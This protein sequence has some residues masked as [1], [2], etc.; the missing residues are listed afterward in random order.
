MKHLTNA[1]LS[2][3]SLLAA[4]G[5]LLATPLLSSRTWRALAQQAGGGPIRWSLTGVTDLVSLDPAKA[6]DLPGFTVIGVLYGGLVKLDESLQVAPS[7][8]EEW[9]V[10]TD[11]LTYTFTLRNGIT[12]S[13]GTPITADDVVWTFNH[14]LDPTTG[15][16]TG[17]Y[18]FT[19][20]AGADDVAAGKATE[21]SGV[22][23][24]DDKTVAITIKEPAAYFLSSLVAGPSKILSKTAMAD[25]N[26]EGKITS[27]PFM[28]QTWNHGQSLDLVPNPTFYEPVTGVTQLS[29]VFNQDSETGYQLY[30]TG[31]VDILGSSQAP[32]PAARVPEV[33]DS[34]DFKSTPAFN[35]RYVGFNNVQKPFDDVRVRQALTHAIDRDTLANAVLGGTVTPT[36]R[37]LPA[38]FPASDKPVKG[39][40]FDPAAA[41][42]LLTQAGID[43]KSLSFTLTYGVEGD[44]EKVVTVLQSMW[45]E[46]LGISVK[47]EPLELATFSSRLNDTYVD[48][49]KGIQSYYSIWGADYP[50][51]QNFLSLQLQTNVGNNNG[52][53]SNAD[54]DRLTKEADTTVDDFAKRAEL[55]NQAEQ[56][57]VDQVGWLPLF[58]A[59]V[60]V[61]VRDCI[62]GIHV[63]GMD[64]LIPSW[65]AVTG[66]GS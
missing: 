21:A 33:K 56:I 43:P 20:I 23:K 38:G 55:Y 16:W 61:L 41:K 50:D 27:G 44:N 53:W 59:K 11:S 65:S 22:K 62:E 32:I 58:N 54:F 19:L 5:G 40:S 46:N 37:I 63:T 47:L 45:Q 42:D 25:P 36:D 14:A 12:F 34:P 18:Y 7:L 24:I 6:S 51:P 8:A 26:N 48:P 9:S 52:H 39:L 66:C 60:N 1:G 17:A 49:T 31:K 3:R 13:D 10:S 57:A 35:T 4:G 28:V 15:G 64:Y 29:F 2:R 30:R